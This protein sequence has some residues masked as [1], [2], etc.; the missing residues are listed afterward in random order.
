MLRTRA[1]P[2]R[3]RTTATLTEERRRDLRRRETWGVSESS[4]ARRRRRSPRHCLR[5]LVVAVVVVATSI[6]ATSHSPD[7]LRRLR[8]SHQHGVTS[9]LPYLR[10]PRR[11]I[12]RHRRIAFTISSWTKLFQKHFGR[13]AVT[14]LLTP[15]AC[16]PFLVLRMDGL[17]ALPSLR[18]SKTKKE[19][20]T[21]TPMSHEKVSWR[22]STRTSTSRINSASSGRRTS[23]TWWTK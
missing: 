3:P 10:P 16:T 23:R 6:I 14:T 13:R 12:H 21:S 15:Q 4:L 22:I 9:L 11:R 8:R 7:C 5:N 18:Q 2:R 17:E 20:S 1:A 19:G